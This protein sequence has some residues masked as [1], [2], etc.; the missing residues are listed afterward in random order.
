MHS[1]SVSFG[2]SSPMERDNFALPIGNYADFRASSNP[3]TPVSE[4]RLRSLSSDYRLSSQFATAARAWARRSGPTGRKGDESV[5]GESSAKRKRL[6]GGESVLELVELVLCT[7][8]VFQEKVFDEALEAWGQNSTPA[9]VLSAFA[10]IFQQ[11]LDDPVFAVASARPEMTRGECVIQT[12][13]RLFIAMP[14]QLTAFQQL[15]PQVFNTHLQ[16]GN[17]PRARLNALLLSKS[18]DPRFERMIAET[19]ELVSAPF[20]WNDKVMPLCT[21]E[22]IAQDYPTL[23]QATRTKEDGTFIH[24]YSGLLSLLLRLTAFQGG[25]ITEIT[26]RTTEVLNQFERNVDQQQFLLSIF[27]KLD[28]RCRTLP[29]DFSEL[30]LTVLSEVAQNGVHTL[31]SVTGER[32]DLCQRS[33]TTLLQSYIAAQ[34]P[35]EWK[36]LFREATNI[37]FMVKYMSR[38]SVSLAKAK[39]IE[40]V[41][42]KDNF[43]R[44]AHAAEAQA[45]LSS[46]V[47]DALTSY[48]DVGIFDLDQLADIDFLTHPEQ[49]INLVTTSRETH[50]EGDRSDMALMTD[51]TAEWMGHMMEL[52]FPPLTPHH[53]Q[54]FMVMMMTRCFSQNLEGSTASK[55]KWKPKAFTAQMATGEGKS[56]VIAML[57]IFIVQKFRMASSMNLA[58]NAM[59]IYCLKSAINRRFLRCMVEGRLDEELA[60]TVLIVDKVDDLIVNERPNNHY[61]KKDVHKTPALIKCYEALRAGNAEKPAEVDESMWAEVREVVQYCNDTGRENVHYRTIVDEGRRKVVMLD[62]FGNLPKV[63][64]TSKWLQYLIF[65]RYAAIFGLTGSVGGKA[66]LAYLTKTYYAVKF[67]VPRFLDTCVE[68]LKSAEEVIERVAKVAREYFRKVPVLIISSS[69]DELTKILDAVRQGG[70]IPP[71]DVMLRLSEFGE[72]GRSLKSGWQSII[73]DSTKRL[74]RKENL[75]AV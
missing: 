29:Q 32:M 15:V 53:T 62:E 26:R 49:L 71:P 50:Q 58:D 42:N 56:I 4:S 21:K 33:M 74:E 1:T 5:S 38:E 31:S 64:L 16:L 14:A 11:R 44:M 37:A 10:N 45:M 6:E 3:S 27:A 51:I 61:V 57:A 39:F 35:V 55:A 48:G 72:D 36:Q 7:S 19:D 24:L 60:R 17:K 70:I 59:V 20:L 41:S 65:K 63:P 68:L 73:D 22:R 9:E 66:E 75:D 28:H 13:A 2:C 43:K 12:L 52:K 8:T 69:D 34:P 40:S 23:N 46:M 30:R 47:R 54:A 25:D 18:F 67:D